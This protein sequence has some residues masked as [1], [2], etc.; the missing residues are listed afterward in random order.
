[1]SD[2]TRWLA[3][4]GLEQYEHVFA[5]NAIDWN[6]LRNLSDQDLQSL[7]VSLGHRRQLLK[8]LAAMNHETE[9]AEIVPALD[10]SFFREPLDAVEGE[11]RHLTV[12]F[13][14]MVGSTMLSQALDP[15]DL[16]NVMLAFHGTVAREFVRFEGHVAR[17]LGDA[18]LA[19]F[20]FPFAHEDDVERAIRASLATT[21]A[22]AALD[23]PTNGA[24][25][26]RIGVATGPV[27]VGNSF[28]EGMLRESAAVGAIPNLAARLQGIASPQS[29]VIGAE[30]KQIAGDLFAY[31]NLGRGSVKGFLEPIQAWR[32]V[33]VREAETRFEA[34]HRS[35]LPP[36]IGRENE[37]EQIYR[38]WE[39]AKNG[40]RQVVLIAGEPGIGKSRLAQELRQRVGGEPCTSVRYQCSAHFT[41]S[42]LYPVIEQLRRAA[43]IERK[44]EPG[45]RLDK[46]E[47]MLRLAADDITEIAPLF[48][49]LL[50]IPTGER[51]SL[52]EFAP[53]RWKERTFAALLQQM[54]RLA[55]RQPL[56]VLFEDAH[57]IDPTSLELLDRCIETVRTLSV[58]FII[59]FRPEFKPTWVRQPH[60]THLTLNQISDRE[61]RALARLSAC[62][63]TLPDPLLTEIVDKADGVP[64]FVEELTK[65]VLESG[66]V[67][68]EFDRYIVD[69]PLAKLAI[70]GTICDSLT[71]RL[72]RMGTSKRVAQI[73]AALG[74][75]ISYQLVSAV[76]DLPEE[77][78]ERSLRR[79]VRAGLLS[80][81]GT[82]PDANYVFKHALVQEAA[83]KSI[84]KSTR[85]QLHQHIAFTLERQFPDVSDNHPELRAHHYT[86]AGLVESA[87]EY[88]RKAGER[89]AQRWANQ[90]A[91]GYLRRGLALA[92]NIAN[93][94]ARAR[95]ELQ[96]LVAIGVPLRL[97]KGVESL[98]VEHSYARARELCQQLGEPRCEFPV[99]WGLW[100]HFRNIDFQK[101]RRLSQELEVL[102]ENE[103]NGALL[104]QAHHAEWTTHLF[105][106]AWRG[107]VSHCKV[108]IA[109][110]DPVAHHGTAAIYGGHDP[111]VCGY[112]IE[113]LCLWLEGH[114]AEARAKLAESLAL[115]RTLPQRASYAHALEFGVMLMH[116]L[117]EPNATE[118]YAR[119]IIE[120]GEEHALERYVASGKLLSGWAN[121]TYQRDPYSL[122][123]VGKGISALRATGFPLPQSYFLGVA[124]EAALNVGLPREAQ[125]LLSEALHTAERQGV[126]YWE[127]EL[128]RLNG[129]VLLS[130]EPGNLHSIEA[131]Y[132]KAI[133]AAREQGAR[134]LEL[135]AATSL[136]RLWL[137]QR[138][139]KDARNLLVPF[140]GRLAQG[141]GDADYC[142]ARALLTQLIPT[143]TN[144]DP[145]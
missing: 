49:T 65:A 3:G 105:E 142:D 132:L 60:V 88:W 128:H 34:R 26:V 78:L 87:V 89:S 74:R 101:S 124:A 92:T 45:R 63:K 130:L 35:D 119:E 24:L 91:I 82:L 79:L 15:E 31:E 33:G 27:V 126:G 12:V 95:T 46:M 73:C 5:E 90:E 113:A 144:N 102:A 83:Y 57:W 112:G 118:T 110:Y 67:R 116:M 18:V 145:L 53:E 17:F 80:G 48:A 133:E 66:A 37:T 98:E 111:A 136:A 40:E 21:E 68:E 107:A 16:R 7:G 55:R 75:E 9:V 10:P 96:L 72:D 71:S 85:R 134:L 30:T 139:I 86:E 19:Y 4:L 62:G 109:L 77:T 108:G 28:G 84:L 36:L 23:A 13:C 104:I 141:F 52:P 43:D 8:A 29:V 11:R 41:N 44:D 117:R 103:N 14:D 121:S 59:T 56:L 94:D 50:S 114:P 25:A 70:P 54:T 137:Q 123:N 38:L 1:M 120:I 58:L 22:V 125:A 115:G 61:C 20:G 127:P 99:V 6:V 42:A 131:A 122:M 106:C 64:L 76:A 97:T 51:Y 140:R 2:V 47:E 81:R 138:K 69:G 93:E 100:A 32:V 143:A 135:R 129:D 39:K